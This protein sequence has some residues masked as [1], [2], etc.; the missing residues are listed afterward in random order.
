MFWTILVLIVGIALFLFGGM[1]AKQD[2]KKTTNDNKIVKKVVKLVSIILIA[3]CVCRLYTPYY[4]THTNPMILQDMVSAM[5]EQQNAEKN[6]AI[7]KYVRSNIGE[8]IADA[9]VWG[10]EDAKHTI[11]LWS[12]YSCPYCRRVHGELARVMADRDDVRVVLKNFSIHGE[13]SDAPAKAVIAAKLQ[14]NDKAAALDRKLM[15]KEYY[16]QDDMKDRSKLGEKIQK[17]VMNLAAEVGLDTAQ[18]ER[19]MKGPVVARELKNVRDLAQKFEISGTPY[20]VIGERAF[21]GA[22]PYDQIIEA[23]DK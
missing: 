3:G 13:L 5:Q 10:N 11:F 16:T 21:P 17:N 4:L 20:L 19:D 12:D 14:G 22:I 1:F 15:E 8:M 9:P 18:L 6:K 2:G 23:L 7:R